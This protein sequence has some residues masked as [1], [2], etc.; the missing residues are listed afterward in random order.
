MLSD[1]TKQTIKNLPALLSIKEAAD[2]FQVKRLTIYR[3]VY[4]KKLAAYKDNEGNWCISRCNIEKFCSK[5][6]NL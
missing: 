1:T 6:C 5:N 2:F 3:L 4:K